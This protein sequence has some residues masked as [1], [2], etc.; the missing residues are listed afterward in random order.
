[1]TILLILVAALLPVYLLFK[2]M[3]AQ[4]SAQPEPKEWLRKGIWYGVLSAVLVL[5]G[6]AFIPDSQMLYPEYKGSVFGAMLEALYDAALPEEAAKLL[7][8][9]LLLRKNPYFDEHLDGIVYATCIGLGF[10]GLENI[11]Y[12]MSNFD[13]L[14]SVAISRALF[15]VPGHFFFAVVM[16]YFYSLAHFSRVSNRNK[17]VYM[18]MAYLVPVLLHATYDGILMVSEVA[19]FGS[20]MLFVLF[21]IFCNSMR[22]K[23]MKRIAEM[24]ERDRFRFFDFLFYQ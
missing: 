3:K 14:L 19:Q 18:V 15:A 23:G 21:L 6:H 7:M 5:I 9:W 2:Y 20:G 24:K 17:K 4:D 16:G 8:L 11:F 22:K 1:M 10:A 13:N 12:L